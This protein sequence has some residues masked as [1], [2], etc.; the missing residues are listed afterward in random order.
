MTAPNLTAR[1]FADVA[2]EPERAE[3]VPVLSVYVLRQI[4]NPYGPDECY[5]TI[6]AVIA[7]SVEQARRAVI[8]E[9]GILHPT[10]DELAALELVAERLAVEPGVVCECEV[11]S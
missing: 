11:A 8:M 6:I 9:R 3:P 7:E 1:A 5:E 10:V 2:E 4:R